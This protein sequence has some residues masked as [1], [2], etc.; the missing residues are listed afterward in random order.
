MKKLRILVVGQGGREHA[1]GWQ[2]SQS[3]LVKKIFFAPGNSG[4]ENL[5]ENINIKVDEI[6]KLADFAKKEKIDL[7]IVGPELPL[8][9]G[10]VDFFQKK[11]LKII[12]P[13]KKASLIEGSKIFAKKL[14]SKYN[15]PTAKYE[16][17]T[18]FHLAEKYLKKTTYPLVIKAD[19]LCQGKGTKVCDNQKE[20]E[21]FLKKLMV[22]KIFGSAG[23]KVVIEE[24]LTGQEISFMV[25][26]DGKDFLSFLPSQDHKRLLDNNQGPNTGGMG[27]YAPVPFVNKNLIKRIE[28][29]IVSPT[30]SALAKEGC[31]YQ[32][33]LYPGLIL[34]KK[35]PKVLEFNCRFG[36]PETQP[37][38]MLLQSDLL[39]IFLS[40]IEGKL[41]KKKLVFKKGAAVCVVLAAKG[42]P[43]NYEKGGIIYGLD[44]IKNKDIQVFHAG[45]AKKNN[46]IVVAGGRVLGI[47]GYSSSLF[48]ALKK[49]YKAIGKKGVYFNNMS[50]RK[51]IGQKGLN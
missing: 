13:T 5:G 50:Y 41:K 46:Q 15:I 17:F 33:I 4:T 1:L 44:K 28:K 29:E 19:G 11:G 39:A 38:M 6:E 45:T 2:L 18:N 47:T 27:A 12:G 21:E 37:L 25:I 43:G 20:A 16:I 32:G 3:P 24:C 34:T 9:L 35:G 8:V 40:L 7:I 49:V 30:I 26:T 42:Y 10:I 51:D 36:D 31:S 14:M 23:E 48:L 22:K